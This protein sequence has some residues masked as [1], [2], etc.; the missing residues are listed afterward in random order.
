MRFLA[1]FLALALVAC[2]GANESEPAAE[3]HDDAMAQSEV[4]PEVQPELQAAT[5]AVGDKVELTGV[6]GC[7]HCSYH[8]TDSCAM[9]MSVGDVVYIL[10]GIDD[11]TE[12]FNQRTSGKQIS[13]VGVLTDAGDPKH[14]Q[15]ESHKI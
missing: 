3:T 2:G 12:A 1:L 13:V 10:D 11:D 5:Y 6:A 8:V 4:Q 7:G 14:I 15:V 9:A